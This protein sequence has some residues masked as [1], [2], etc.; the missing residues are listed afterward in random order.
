[1]DRWMAIFSILEEKA[2]ISVTVEFIP[3]SSVSIFVAPLKHF[4][5]GISTK[6]NTPPACSVPSGTLCFEYLAPL[7]CAQTSA[8]VTPAL[9]RC[10]IKPA[11]PLA[12]GRVIGLTKEA[13]WHSLHLPWRAEWFDKSPVPSSLGWIWPA[14]RPFVS[15]QISQAY[16][17]CDTG[18]YL[19]TCNCSTTLANWQ[20]P[21]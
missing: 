19:L 14:C 16:L 7:L 3:R 12:N 13:Q 11:W 15:S 21:G 1:M 6:A 5:L 8:S 20:G 2:R 17:L 10:W 18:F 9:S 4:A